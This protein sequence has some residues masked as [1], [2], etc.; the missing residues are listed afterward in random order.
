MT[1]VNHRG[2]AIPPCPGPSGAARAGEITRAWPPATVRWTRD[3][4]RG[5]PTRFHAPA[6]KT[7]LPGVEAW[8]HRR[9]PGAAHPPGHRRPRGQAPWP[10]TA[11]GHPGRPAGGA[12]GQALQGHGPGRGVPLRPRRAST[13]PLRRPPRLRPQPGHGCAESPGPG[14]PSPAGPWTTSRPFPRPG[15]GARHHRGRTRGGDTRFLPRQHRLAVAAPHRTDTAGHRAHPLAP[16][17][18]TDPAAGAPDPSCAEPGPGGTR[19][20]R[21]PVAQ[22]RRRPPGAPPQD[23]GDPAGPHG[24][25]TGSAVGGSTNAP[26][27]LQVLIGSGHQYAE[28]T[29][30]AG[31]FQ[32]SDDTA[33]QRLED[34]PKDHHPVAAPAGGEDPAP[35]QRTDHPDSADLGRS[36]TT[37]TGW[38]EPLTEHSDRERPPRGGPHRKRTWAPTVGAVL[39]HLFESSH[40]RCPD[41]TTAPPGGS[42]RAFASTPEHLRAPRGSTTSPQQETPHPTQWSGQNLLLHRGSDT[43]LEQIEERLLPVHQLLPPALR[44][45][46]P[47]PADPGGPIPPAGTSRLRQRAEPGLRGHREPHQRSG[48]GPLPA[49]ARPEGTD[50]PD[51]DPA[52][53]VPR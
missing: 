18:G 50:Q 43:T 34:Q 44:G 9:R 12:R 15:G 14:R 45:P 30:T 3:S 29:A 53:P 17:A 52:I 49:P 51:P 23:P 11:G 48:P 24:A 20:R 13:P 41:P 32:E 4:W 26:P 39:T 6:L 21:A 16:R 36:A 46:R 5:G 47:S 38:R 1:F 28:T 40:T 2:A 27:A 19:C 37:I 42:Y 7:R 35:A 33:V 25:Q 10:D 31:T 22:P 8:G